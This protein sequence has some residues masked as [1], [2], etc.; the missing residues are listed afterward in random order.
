MSDREKG[1][2]AT[3]ELSAGASVPETP[4]LYEAQVPYIT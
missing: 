4:P 2:A 1:I 3:N